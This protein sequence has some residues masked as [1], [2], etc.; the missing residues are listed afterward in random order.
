[1]SEGGVHVQIT[2]MANAMSILGDKSERTHNK[3]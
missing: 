3:C 1:M 2:Y